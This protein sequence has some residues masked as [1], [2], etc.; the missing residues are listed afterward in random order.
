L[1]HRSALLVDVLKRT[2]RMLTVADTMPADAGLAS[3]FLAVNYHDE[4]LLGLT[5]RGCKDR[6]LEA[7]AAAKIGVKKV[8]KWKE[9]KKVGPTRDD[10]EKAL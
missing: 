5:R 7:A 8:K 2:V 10:C 9:F 3:P 6:G 1:R 4:G